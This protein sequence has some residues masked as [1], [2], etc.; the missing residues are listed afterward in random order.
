V[1]KDEVKKFVDEKGCEGCHSDAGWQLVKFDHSITKYALDGKHEKVACR[2]CHP[3]KD[4]GVA[5]PAVTMVGA[6]KLCQDCHP[7]IHLGQF[8]EQVVA[9]A[10]PGTTNC[11]RC[12]TPKDWK[13]VTFDHNRDS[14][15][16]L[17]GAHKNVPCQKCHPLQTSGE[18]KWVLYKPLGITCASCH[19]G[20]VEIERKGQS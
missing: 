11:V 1:H 8:A 9:P 6:G 20:A 4:K 18:V 12:H 19:S 15:Y 5:S 16:K 14:R 10:A 17:D 7:D 3:Q 13:V 2:K